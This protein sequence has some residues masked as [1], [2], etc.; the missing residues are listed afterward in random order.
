MPDPLGIG[1]TLEDF[2]LEGTEQLV[3][4]RL[5]SL[6]R[7]GAILL[8]TPFNIFAEIPLGP[9]DL[10]VSR[11]DKRSRTSSSEQRRSRGQACGSR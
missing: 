11:L 6:T 9:L 4:D 5:K 3:I 10:V 2:Q 7:T 1:T 8:A